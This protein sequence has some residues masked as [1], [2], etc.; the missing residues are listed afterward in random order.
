[1]ARRAGRW[2]GRVLPEWGRRLDALSVALGGEE[3]SA[4]PSPVP[5]PAP[6][7]RPSVVSP[8]RKPAGVIDALPDLEVPRDGSLAERL[9]GRLP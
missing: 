1:M 3:P 6:S 4:P 9:E 7:P 8:S 5:A 2:A